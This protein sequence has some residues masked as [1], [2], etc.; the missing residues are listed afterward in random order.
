MSRAAQALGLFVIVAG[1]FYWWFWSVT[2][3]RLWPWPA[4]ISAPAISAEQAHIVKYDASGKRLWELEART[5][6]TAEDESIAEEVSVRFFDNEGHEVLRVIAP[7]ARLN[8]HTQDLELLGAISATGN[9]FSFTA[10]N[11]FWD[12]QRKI[13]ATPSV[14]RIERD[15][16]T[17]TG[18]GLEYSS[19][20]GLATIT[21]A[22][23]LML[24][25]KKVGEKPLLLREGGGVRLQE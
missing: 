22:A 15:G 13:L 20:T 2:T 23:Q 12:N 18:R 24:F 7:Q 17:L 25:P 8:N 3:P 6:Q 14:V 4:E 21:S 9:E 19:E 5:V 16:F 10:E 11:L 1:L